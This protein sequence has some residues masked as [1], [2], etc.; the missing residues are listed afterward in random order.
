MADLCA[1]FGGM[2]AGDGGGPSRRGESQEH[3]GCA[4]GPKDWRRAR[5]YSRFPQRPDRNGG[6]RAQTAYAPN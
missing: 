1:G 3:G 2:P 5:P 4:D 6:A